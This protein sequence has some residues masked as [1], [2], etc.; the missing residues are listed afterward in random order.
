MFKNN[1][2]Q[3]YNHLD[4]ST[5]ILIMLMGAFLLGCLLCWLLRQSLMKKSTVNIGDGHFDTSDTSLA[6]S[7]RNSQVIAKEEDNHNGLPNKT[8][9]ATTTKSRAIISDFKIINGITPQ[10]EEL[11][12]R[13][14]INSFSALSNV[15]PTTLNEILSSSTT[16]KTKKQIIKTW[17]HQAALA[18]K[19]DWRKLS[20]YQDFIE[21]ALLSKKEESEK[22]RKNN[23]K[24]T[25]KSKNKTNPKKNNLQKIKGINPQ[26]EQILNS[27][28]IFTFEQLKK[29]DAE[30]L[31]NHISN[32]NSQFKNNQTATWSH[33]ASMAEKEQWKELA[34]YQE[35]M[36]DIKIDSDNLAA[37]IK[38][39]KTTSAPSTTFEKGI[40]QEK[41]NTSSKFDP[42]KTDKKQPFVSYNFSQNEAPALNPA[43][44]DALNLS[45]TQKN[46]S[47]SSL[48]R[49]A[50]VKKTDKNT[51]DNLISKHD[52]SYGKSKALQQLK[53]DTQD[54]RGDDKPKTKQK[55]D[56]KLIKGIDSKIEKVLN[57]ADI[58]TFEDLKQSTIDTLKSILSDAGSKYQK[59]EPKTW[60]VQ[61]EMAHNKNWSELEEYQHFLRKP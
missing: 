13:K 14:D 21:Q 1:V 7:N 52:S 20:E 10:I 8:E 5:E 3:T 37:T 19:G 51:P 6:N 24:K 50:V 46:P 28:G 25:I 35:F 53:Q 34:I 39:P 44:T 2:T 30:T 23:T 48:Y 43:D 41:V 61:A 47:S 42:E 26:I 12:R 31:R 40:E 18:A 33:Q 17:P 15:N 45:N 58:L 36:D 55:N 9:S 60:P 57:N 22:K 54:H 16:E 56:L 29:A 38:K 11:L 59:Y 32:A 49:L 27:K 4:A